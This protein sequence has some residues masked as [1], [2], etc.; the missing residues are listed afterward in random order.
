MAHTTLIGRQS[1]AHDDFLLPPPNPAQRVDV[2]LD[3]RDVRRLEIHAALTIA[4]IAPMPGDL[5]AIEHLSSL[6]HSVHTALH[7]WLTAS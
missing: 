2:V 4:G 1:Q 5:E 7:R 6:P 3:P